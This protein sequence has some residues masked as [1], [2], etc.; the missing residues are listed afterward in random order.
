MKTKVLIFG[1]SGMLGSSMMRVFAEKPD[2]EVTGTVRSP[3]SRN[4]ENRVDPARIVDSID[5]EDISTVRD[6]INRIVPD[7]VVN[8]VG[9][10]KQLPNAE[11]PVDAITLNALFPHYLAR[12]CSD[13]DARLIH[14]STDCVFT[15]LKG[16]YHEDDIP[17]AKDFYGRSKLLGEVSY[18]NA[19]TL[20]TS[21]IGHELSRKNGLLEWFL[22]QNA[23]IKGFKKAIFS[24]FPTGELARVVRDVVIPNSRLSGLHHV[25]TEAIN[26]FDLL[27]IIANEYG[28]DILIKPSD[29]VKIDR[30]LNSQKFRDLTG[31]QP[32]NWEKLVANMKNFG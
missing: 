1:A 22:A 16:D 10:V 14:I 17:D 5:V 19:I 2:F 9:L 12:F 18:G 4:F 23:P 11:D 15:G 28:R 24:G 31:Y 21:I 32:P 20:R 30:S 13:I 6:V 7:V 3:S 8:C 26:K 29:S 25:S 27:T